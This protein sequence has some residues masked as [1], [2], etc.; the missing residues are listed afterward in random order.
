[1]NEQPKNSLMLR[2]RPLVFLLPGVITGL[3]ILGTLPTTQPILSAIPERLERISAEVT[4]AVVSPLFE[5]AE[6]E[7]VEPEELPQ[8]PYTDGVYTGSSQGYGGLVTVQVTVENG[9]IADIEILSAPGETEPYIT[10]AR[11]IIG[12][13]IDQQTWEVDAVSGAT[14]SSRG[15]LGAVQN[16]LTGETVENEAPAQ[17]APAGTTVQDSFTEPSSYKDGTYYGS[18][19]GFGGSI[20]VE[21]VIS[22]GVITSIRIVSAPYET[23]EYLNRA[24]SVISSILSTGSPNV[25]AV[26]GAT[27]SSTGIINA[28]KRALSQAAIDG[29]E[30]NP[31]LQ[32]EEP[33]L[34]IMPDE[35]LV[36]GEYIGIGEGFGGEIHVRVTVNEGRITEITVIS[37]EDETPEYFNRATG[38]IQQIINGQSAAVDVVSGATY[39]SQGVLEAVQ[40]ALK[41]A[42]GGDT[43]G[44]DDSEN[45]D[46]ESTGTEDIEQDPNGP[47]DSGEDKSE[48]A[49]YQDGSYIASGWCSDEDGEFLYGITVNVVIEDGAIAAIEAIKTAD[50]SDDPELNDTYLGYA[51]NGRTR[52]GVEY[53]GIPAQILKKQGIDEIDAVS[54]ATYSSEVI[55]EL[56]GE[57]L[58]KAVVTDETNEAGAATKDGIYTGSAWCDDGGTFRYLLTVTATVSD[59]RI[60]SVDVV[61]T[62]DESEDPEDNDVYLNFAVNGR[63]RRGITYVGVPQQITDKQSADEIDAV[64]GATYSSEAIRNA[65]LQALS[66][67]APA[68]ADA[69]YEEN[70][71]TDADAESLVDSVTEMPADAEKQSDGAAAFAA[72]DEPEDPTED[73]AALGT[74]NNVD[75]AEIDQEISEP[76]KES[77]PPKDEMDNAVEYAEQEEPDHEAE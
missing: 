24:K 65:A 55:R 53:A 10:L 29:K 15:I 70:T 26:S 60:V 58:A 20:Q 16:A 50:E 51:V 27:Y 46:S 76:P 33:D 11:T 40:N 48:T 43:I 69:G 34:S 73:E 12:V 14:Y 61:K 47:D 37:A 39:S 4:E 66:G 62:A 23:A 22:G 35:K 8:G 71:M 7:D 18:A 5:E 9:R 19:E 17:T 59:G 32:D 75:T 1:M 68:D 72:S 3:V 25:D 36:D 64:S 21:V 6:P 74:D 42:A 63:T 2:L 41:L 56:S 49:K 13:V 57:A 45:H 54:G 67:G 44:P 31:D 52:I 77:E 30:E 28:V 38:L